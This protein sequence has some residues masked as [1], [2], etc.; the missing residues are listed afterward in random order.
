MIACE[1]KYAAFAGAERMLQV[2]V[3]QRLPSDNGD[4]FFRVQ[5]RGVS[6]NSSL[7]IG[8]VQLESATAPVNDLLLPE[9]LLCAVRRENFTHGGI[10]TASHVTVQAKLMAEQKQVAYCCEKFEGIGTEATEM[11]LPGIA[12]PN[13]VDVSKLFLAAI[14]DAPGDAVYLQPAQ[15][16]HAWAPQIVPQTR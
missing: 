7:R 11:Q 12:L 14:L 4:Q 15:A 10:H 9:K 13:E 2:V 6:R 5:L 1:E 3:A 16:G 8:W